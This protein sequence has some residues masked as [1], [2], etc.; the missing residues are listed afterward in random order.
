M[1]GFATWPY[2]VTKIL[3]IFDRES[4]LPFT[5]Y[6]M[7]RDRYIQFATFTVSITFSLRMFLS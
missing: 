4:V 2:R 5:L 7:E 6:A 1:W 3:I